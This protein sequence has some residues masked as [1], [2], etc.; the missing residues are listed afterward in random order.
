MVRMRAEGLGVA[1]EVRL[2]SDGTEFRRICCGPP[3]TASSA[4]KL[5]FVAIRYIPPARCRDRSRALPQCGQQFPA[6]CSSI[7]PQFIDLPYYVF[8]EVD[9]LIRL[10]AP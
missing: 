5:I 8:G 6:R 4:K 2:L 1:R 7:L 9:A 10:R 3:T